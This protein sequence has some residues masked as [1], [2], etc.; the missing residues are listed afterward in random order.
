MTE[1]R[2][3]GT[4]GLYVP[5]LAFGT[6]TFGGGPDWP[7]GNTDLP[8]AR[9]LVDRCLDAGV[10]FFDSADVYG[11]GQSQ[12]ILGQA[13]E[14]KRDRALISAKVGLAVGPEPGESGTGRAHLID[15]CEAAL[16]RLRT[17]RIDLFQLHAFDSRVPVEETLGV[18]DDLVRAGK[19]RF[20][21]ASNFAAWQLM[22]ALATS[23]R[24][25]LARF[26]STQSYYSLVGRDWEIELLPLSLDQGLGTLVWSPLAG[27]WLGGDVRRDS[28]PAPGSRLDRLGDAGPP[29]PRDLLYD[30]VDVLDRIAAETGKTVAQI[31][32]NWL[33]R[34]PTVA[35]VIVGADDEAQLEQN[36]GALGWELDDDQVAALDAASSTALGYPHYLYHRE[37]W[38]ASLTMPPLRRAG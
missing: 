28:P 16:R 26:G 27:G 6:G 32:L 10:G 9:R 23:D 15:A 14:G 22:K 20:L 3:L 38:F 11:A 37:D 36:L 18:L 8:E 2:Q 13:L 17:D 21:G 7:Y 4:S 33:L 1:R 29:V 34:R 35:A 25:G 31:S 5:P 24:L 12:E 30:V 19:V